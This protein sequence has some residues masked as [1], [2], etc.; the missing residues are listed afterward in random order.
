M[1]AVGSEVVKPWLRYTIPTVDSNQTRWPL[2]PLWTSIIQHAFDS[3]NDEPARELI[4]HKKQQVNIDAMTASL[5]GY[6]ATRT[7]LQCEQDG[8][9]VENM[10]TK[11][12]LDDLYGAFQKRWEEKGITFQQ[13]L[14][15]KRHRYYLREEKTREV[16]QR[17]AKWI[18]PVIDEAIE[19]G[20]TDEN[21]AS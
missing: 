21:E 8:M 19:G 4:R 12:A 11:W 20:D 10:A 16:E 15:A 13:M 18:I 2:H 9:P 17:R 5:A 14:Q 1:Y 3:L 7:M 6:L